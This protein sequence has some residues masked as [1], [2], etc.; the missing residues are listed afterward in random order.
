MKPYIAKGISV[1]IPS[2]RMQNAFMKNKWNYCTNV[3]HMVLMED[4][5]QAYFSSHSPLCL[6]TILPIVLY[7][8]DSPAFKW[9]LSPS[10]PKGYSIRRL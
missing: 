8:T 1:M 5:E 7:T 6:K 10:L 2:L 9:T 3:K 4:S